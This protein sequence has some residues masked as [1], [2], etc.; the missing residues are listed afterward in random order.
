[1]KTLAHILVLGLIMTTA[2]CSKSDDTAA[3][4]SLTTAAKQDIITDTWVVGSYIDNGKD[5]TYRYTGYSFVFADNG[6]LTASID[7]TTFTGTWMIGSDDSGSD[8]SGSDPGNDSKLIITITGNYQMDELTDDFLISGI[9]AT[10][11]LLKDD[12]LTKIKEL[13][14]VRK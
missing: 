10:E 2:A 8:D 12:N 13:R 6:T 5:E 4:A 3:P 9:S 7:G 11:I 14:F 1:M